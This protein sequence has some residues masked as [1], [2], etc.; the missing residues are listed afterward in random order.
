MPVIKRDTTSG[1]S[2]GVVVAENPLVVRTVKSQGIADSVR[3][4]RSAR[5]AFC[6]NPCPVAR[7]GLYEDTS[8]QVQQDFKIAFHANTDDKYHR[9]I[10][11]INR[12]SMGFS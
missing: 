8:I 3:A 6:T 10:Y 4:L 9:M 12:R 5:H 11:E 2:V 1:R 7:I